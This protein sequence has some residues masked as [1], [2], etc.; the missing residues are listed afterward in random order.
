LSVGT[1]TQ[2]LAQ[3]A[4]KAG[5][6]ALAGEHGA[7]YD[8]LVYGAALCLFHLKRQP[9]LPVAADVARRAIESGEALTRFQQN[10]AR[11]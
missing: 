5:A 1:D 6:A 3:A 2:A 9:S 11:R 7:A 8:S 10:Q 4:A